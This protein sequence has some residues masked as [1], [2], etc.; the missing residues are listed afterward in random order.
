VNRLPKVQGERVP[1]EG[2]VDHWREALG[3][4]GVALEMEGIYGYIDAAVEARRPLCSM[5]GRCCNFE[6]YGHRLYL[7]G[8][9]TAYTLAR[10][11]GAPT[12]GAIAAARSRGGCPF[13][14]GKLCSIHAFRPPACR[15]YFCDPTAGD[16]MQE[17]SERLLRELRR[18]HERHGV[19]YRYGEW[20][21]MLEMFSSPA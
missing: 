7:T 14:E 19:E 20:R 21:S 16:W 15:V 11:D 6:A 8:L 3:R 12:A 2:L 13:Q 5:S 1:D 17:T 9:E 4:P 10:L 18:L